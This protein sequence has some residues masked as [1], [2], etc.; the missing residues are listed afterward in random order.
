MPTYRHAGAY[1]AAHAEW[2]SD[3]KTS[4]ALSAPQRSVPSA[5]ALVCW[6]LHGVGAEFHGGGGPTTE[7]PPSRPRGTET[8]WKDLMRPEHAAAGPGGS[9]KL[10]S[11]ECRPTRPRRNRMEPESGGK[12]SCALTTP[13]RP[14][15]SARALVCWELHGVGAELHG[16]KGP[17]TD[18][19]PSRPRGTQT[20]WKDLMRPEHAAVGPGGS[21]ILRANTVQLPSPECCPTRPRRGRV[22]SESGEKTSCALKTPHRPVP[23]ARALVCWELHGVGAEFHGGRGPTTRQTARSSAW[24][25]NPM[26]RPHAP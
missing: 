24:N 11:P 25:P 10:P 8:R 15:P 19:L 12:T 13:N 3:A 4:C 14:V 2:K 17:T 1:P 21:M 26:E 7:R 6:E 5:R 22:E 18:R 16:G 20:R 23:S 9:V